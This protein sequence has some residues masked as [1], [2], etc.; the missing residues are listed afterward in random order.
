MLIEKTIKDLM[1]WFEL[2]LTVRKQAWYGDFYFIIKEIT[3]TG[4]A[5]GIR[6]KRGKLYDTW[7]CPL[8]DIFVL[9]T[10][11]NQAKVAK[12][13]NNL[14]LNK[15]NY[16]SGI[17]KLFVQ[18]NGK[19]LPATF[20]RFE[21]KEGKDVIYLSCE[22]KTSFYS[23]PSTAFVFPNKDDGAAALAK[24]QREIDL[25]NATNEAV[26]I[27]KGYGKLPVSKKPAKNKNDELAYE[28]EIHKQV[29]NKILQDIE[30]QKQLIA[31]AQERLSFLS[32]D[33]RNA[34]IEARESGGPIDQHTFISLQLNSDAAR[35]QQTRAEREKDRLET[36]RNRPYFARVD[37]GK[38]SK[39][40]HTAYIGDA[41]IKDYV[42]D[43]RHPEIGNA[44]YHSGILTTSDDIVIALKRTFDI[45]QAK[46]YDFDD[47][48]NI[49]HS[50]AFC[51]SSKDLEMGTD[52]LLTK[53][54]TIS[55]EDKT[56]HDIIKTIQT[57]QYD[58][59]TSDFYRNAVINGCAGSG[60]TMILYHRL[61]YIAYNHNFRTGT[62]F[63]PENVYV[64]SPSSFFDA[65]HSELM[66]KLSI[67]TIRQAPFDKQVENLI[68]NYCAANQMAPFYNVLSL[69]PNDKN[70][71]YNM[72][73]EETFEAFLH[74]LEAFDYEEKGYI[75]WLFNFAQHLLTKHGFASLP[76]ERDPK[77]ITEF[78][79]T[80]YKCA[81][82][83]K[84]QEPNKEASDGNTRKEEYFSK[85]SIATISVENIDAALNA[86]SNASNNYHVR[87]R[88]IDQNDALLKMCLS[89][90]T[91]RSANGS[92]DTNLGE[93]W[94]LL[95]KQDIF[96]KMCA[97]I[98]AEKL[99]A[100]ATKTARVGHDFLVGCAYVFQDMFPTNCNQSANVYFLRALACGYGTLTEAPTHI[101]VDEFQ[102]YS[103]FELRCLKMVFENPVFNL[104][105]DYDQRLEEKGIDLQEEVDALLS[106]QKYNLNVNYRNAAEITQYIN[107]K[108]YKHMQPIGVKGYV[109]ETSFLDCMFT[110]QN[111]T[112][113]IAKDTELIR[114]L[115]ELRFGPDFVRV[116]SETKTIEPDK[117]VLFS[118]SECKGL[119]FDT[120]Y[121]FSS[122]LSENEKY[123][124]YTR[125]LDRLSVITDENLKIIKQTLEAEAAAEKTQKTEEKQKKTQ[126]QNEKSDTETP[127]LSTSMFEP[128]S[129]DECDQIYSE[130]MKSF[131]SEKPD[132]LVHAIALLEL[133]VMSFSK[134]LSAATEAEKAQRRKQYRTNNL[135]QYCG[136]AF[137][138]I[139]TKTCGKCGKKK[140]Y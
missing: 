22:G 69:F 42:V 96:E 52:A 82:F 128:D 92:V 111:R 45:R 6:C 53:L 139:F 3:A 132:D 115:L 32:S 62:P 10:D 119:E 117:L 87:R 127:D 21:S 95:E 9:D 40:L 16:H 90:R 28:V 97:L 35:S 67:D 71:T 84:Q 129:I 38:S 109:S 39:E 72:H 85:I 26:S 46:F 27:A 30:P 4:H 88:R 101:F 102:N 114:D 70:G 8:D 83:K 103:A 13:P 50:D 15:G 11:K 36:I 135:C 110:K 54:L 24:K 1:A 126:P 48:I 25:P 113:I 60:K 74:R 121:V 63:K 64:I 66:K 65:G 124:A 56:T 108:V 59:I 49:Y 118:V 136:G 12:N 75:D 106:P 58:I 138:G 99:C 34:R 68:L 2:P 122:E 116:A 23:F 55:R 44:Y 7:S 77:Q 17:T 130:A 81:C 41:D 112:A 51:V 29:D 57:E 86:M 120:V 123:V 131:L 76:D 78:F 104:Y 133:I 19:I 91:N 20:D 47:E 100:I 107:K 31:D 5:N 125:A 89:Q 33:Y 80:Q 37:C 61:S 98:I 14:D 43:W 93:F 94:T 137:K 79:A 73:N 140:D 105:G 18:R 134:K